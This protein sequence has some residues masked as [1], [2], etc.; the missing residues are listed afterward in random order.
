MALSACVRSPRGVRPRD[1][2]QSPRPNRCPKCPDDNCLL[3]LKHTNH[4]T[5]HAPKHSNGFK[6]E[7]VNYSECNKRLKG[8]AR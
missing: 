8:L 1:T 3:L 7:A 4:P 5:R 2:I 6:R